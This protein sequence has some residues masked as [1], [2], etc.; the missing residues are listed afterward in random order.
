MG[1]VKLKEIRVSAS[2]GGKVQ[3]VKFNYSE[4]FHYSYGETYEVADLTEDE[5]A[6]FKADK[7][8]ELQDEIEGIAQEQV[9]RLM[10]MRDAIRRGD[11]LIS[12][13]AEPID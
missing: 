9:D 1:E 8:K 6:K 5:R 10:E 12:D 4:D 7:T 11:D 13:P 3:V 2:I